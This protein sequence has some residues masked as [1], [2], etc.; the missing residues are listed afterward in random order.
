MLRKQKVNQCQL[1]S[2]V[3]PEN[4]DGVKSSRNIVGSR[5][6]ETVDMFLFTFVFQLISEGDCLPVWHVRVGGEI[7][8]VINLGNF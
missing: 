5:R 8:G 7:G 2:D 6:D 4:P 1:C 3:S